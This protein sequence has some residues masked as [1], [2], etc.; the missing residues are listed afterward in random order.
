MNQQ[1]PQNPGHTPQGEPT[2]HTEGSGFRHSLLER[3]PLIDCIIDGRYR[4]Q[5]LISMGQF[6]RVYQAEQSG[7]GRIVAIKVLIHDDSLEESENMRN[8]F[9]REAGALARLS[10][11]NTVRVFDHGQ[12]PGITWLV[13]EHVEGRTLHHVL[14]AGPIPASTAVEIA[15]QICRSLEEAHQLGIVHRDLKPNNLFLTQQASGEVYVKVMDFGIAKDIQDHSGLT[16]QGTMMGTPT[17]MAPEQVMGEAVDPRTDI[18][19]IGVILYRMLVGRTPYGELS[20]HAV[21]FAHLHNAPLTFAEANATLSLPPTLEWVVMRCLEKNYQARFADIAELRR[22][23]RLCRYALQHPETQID[24]SLAEGRVQAP[25]NMFR[26]GASG[27]PIRIDLGS[28]IASGAGPSSIQG[29]SLP[30]GSVLRVS[31]LTLATTLEVNASPSTSEVRPIAASESA[32]SEPSSQK[33]GWII[34]GLGVAALLA[35]FL[36]KMDQ[37]SP[38]PATPVTPVA[39]PAVAPTPVPAVVPAVVPASTPKVATPELSLIH[40]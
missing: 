35:L 36:W 13:M 8:R 1:P 7:L 11:P 39:A 32:V 4:L 30:T 20:G 29:R 19:A 33:L 9:L 5:K 27:E 16:R 22:A 24:V 37:T 21:L 6:T 15:D 25:E 28:I 14:N 31:P 40:I 26:E 10:H 17:Y 2:G 38:A 34:A 3:D 18:Y 23:L 12:S